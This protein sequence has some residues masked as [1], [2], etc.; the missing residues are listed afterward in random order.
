[1]RQLK[2]LIA[3]DEPFLLDIAVE[4]LTADGHDVMTAADGDEALRLAREEKPDVALI[5]IMMPGVDGRKV[6]EELSSEPAMRDTRLV[7][8]SSLSEKEVSWR[9]TGADAFRS[10]SEDV[11]ELGRFLQ[12]LV[13]GG[14]D[15]QRAA[16]D[17]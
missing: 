13:S 8:Y 7:L 9:E 1:M 2:I 15:P 6:V 11:R 14:G 12:E 3:D 10:K 5:D 16:L 17:G 4:M